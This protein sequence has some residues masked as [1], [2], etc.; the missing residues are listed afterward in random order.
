MDY[1]KQAKDLTRGVDLSKHPSAE[2]LA[3]N[4]VF[5]ADTL[6]KTIEEID[7]QPLTIEYDNGGGQCGTRKNPS[8]ETYNSLFDRFLKGAKELDEILADSNVSNRTQS[9]LAE[10]R[11]IEGKR[12]A[13]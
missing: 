2:T 4:V 8:Y 10:L 12:K 11:L 1:S 9:K 5:M 13:Q 6:N 7:G 3:Y